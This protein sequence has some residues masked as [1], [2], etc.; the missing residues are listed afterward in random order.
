[1]LDGVGVLGELGLD[2]SVRPVPGTLALVDALARAG[3]ECVIVPAANAAEAH[4]VPGVHVRVARTLGELH[5]C[6]KG[7]AP[8]PDPPDPP[9]PPD[10]DPTPTSRSTSLDVRGLA[11]ARHALAATAA[12]GH[13]LLL[14]GPPGVGK[15]MLARRLPTILPELDR[16]AALE[17][18][19]IHSAA[20]AMRDLRAADP[21]AVPRAA[22]QRVDG[23]ARRRRQPARAARRDHARA[24]RRAVPRRDRGVPDAR[25]RSVAPTARRTRDPHQPRVGHA[26]VPRRLPAGR[27]RQPVPVRSRREGL[28]LHRRAA[29]A[30]RPPALGAAARSLR[31]PPAHRDAG[32]EVGASSAEVRGR[33]EAAHP[34]PDAIASRARAGGATRTSRPAR[35]NDSFR[36]HPMRAET[37]TDACRLRRLTGRGAARIRRVARTLADLDDR[38]ALTADD[39]V[40]ASWLREDVW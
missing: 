18:T 7:E 39:I 14:V 16:D 32:H 9:D 19:R 12:G 4:L 38:D 5:A 27:V 25:A 36:S 17:V 40:R 8:W 15:T 1:M 6:L 10:A 20:G 22:P 3:T 31:P 13:H 33:V 29:D 28:P 34:A 24:S 37:W 30:L 2:G 35:S 26:R 21:S 11:N 23:R